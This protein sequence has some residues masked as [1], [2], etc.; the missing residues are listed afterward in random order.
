MAATPEQCGY[1]VSD[2]LTGNGTGGMPSS[3]GIT[4]G[5]HNE[6]PHF[7][8]N[9][10]PK[11]TRGVTDRAIGFMSEQAKAGRPF[12]VQVSYYAVHLS[13]VAREALIKKYEA[14]GEPDR[15]Y[16]AA[17]A[18]MMEEM[19]TGV[20][21]LLD[22]LKAL[23]LDGNTYVV[24]T[25][26]NGGRPTIPGGKNVSTNTPLTG[27]KHTIFEGGIRVPF[28]I[29]GP[30]VPAAAICHTPVASYDLLPTFHALAGGAAL[31][32][33]ELDGANLAPLLH[34]PTKGRLAD[35]KRALYFQNTDYATV[36]IR[37]GTDKLL[38]TLD[39]NGRVSARKFFRVDPDPSEPDNDL[40]ASEPPGQTSWS[41]SG[42]RSL[43]AERADPNSSPY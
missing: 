1:D 24:F 36:A 11:K 29:R 27:G 33:T 37:R 8:D 15:G 43:G 12:Y 23:G 21:R 30:G 22:S 7:V 25:T 14:K 28:I 13:V 6:V 38:A 32:N 3:L 31:Q 10:D 5:S 35:P 26:D 17:W 40:A 39:K 16:T 9:D 42:R 20:G 4:S 41:W 19:D 34:D 2:D 18:A